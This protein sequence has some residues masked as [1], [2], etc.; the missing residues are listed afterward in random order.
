KQP[1]GRLVESAEILGRLW[2][3]D[4]VTHRGRYWQFSD[5]GIRPRPLQSRPPILIGAQA[6][7]A[8]ERAARIGDGWLLVPTPTMEKLAEQMALFKTARAA[9]K[10]PPPEHICRLYEVA[11]ASEEDAAFRRVAPYLLEKYASYAS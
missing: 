10:L 8:I 1:V 9:A 5:A 6:A 11:C 4:R 2:A 3:V 7:P